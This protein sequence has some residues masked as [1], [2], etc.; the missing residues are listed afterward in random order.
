MHLL[1]IFSL[2]V[3]INDY[4]LTFFIILIFLN[5]QVVTSAIQLSDSAMLVLKRNGQRT[6]IKGI[7]STGR[8]KIKFDILLLGGIIHEIFFQQN[9]YI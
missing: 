7:E 2:K 3:K 1:K 4:C 8:F 5:L 9:N 6:K